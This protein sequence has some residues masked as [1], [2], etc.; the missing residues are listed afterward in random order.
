MKYKALYVLVASALTVANASAQDTYRLAFSQKDDIEI[1]LDGY[2]QSNWCQQR[3]KARVVGGPQASLD[4]FAQLLPKLGGLFAAQCPQA[5]LF[6]WTFFDATGKQIAEGQA[7]ASTQWAYSLFEPEQT[8]PEAVISAKDNKTKNGDTQQQE[9][10]QIAKKDKNIEA[11]SAVKAN[12]PEL[13]IAESAKTE[14]KPK[15]PSE[16]K[17]L[18]QAEDKTDI[19]ELSV[20]EQKQTALFTPLSAFAVGRWAPPTE[21]QRKELISG[22]STRKDQNGCVLYSAF[23]FGTQ[24][25]YIQ[26]VS[27]KLTCTQE[28]YLQGQGTLQLMRSDGAALTRAIDVYA[29]NG[30]PFISD[31]KHLHPDAIVYG[32]GSNYWFSVGSDEKLQSHYL[33][34]ARIQNYDGLGLWRIPDELHVLTGST[35]S[36]KQAN[37]IA[38]QIDSA[39]SY[40][41]RVFNSEHLNRVSIRFADDP[42]NGLA[43]RYLNGVLYE[44]D[45]RR[46]RNSYRSPYGPWTYNMQGASNYLFE[47]EAKAQQELE[48]EQERERRRLEEEER[49]KQMRQQAQARA[50]KQKIERQLRENASNEQSRLRQYQLLLEKNLSE[51][52]NLHEHIYRNVRNDFSGLSEYARVL[53]RGITMPISTLVEVTGEKNGKALVSWPYEMHLESI[54][55][56]KKGW[57]WIR[58][59]QRFDTATLDKTGLPMTIVKIEPDSLYA[60]EKKQCTELQ[61]PLALYRL[62][63]SNPQW[64]PSQAEKQVNEA[65]EQ[66]LIY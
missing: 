21:E 10:V 34:P 39:V 14:E 24:D 26:L 57:Y 31:V 1:F 61:D 65:K 12:A 16:S 6:D 28:G 55:K 63:I 41:P 30:I 19:T 32:G 15:E 51:G 60:C 33:V 17:G 23:N 5:S 53:Q 62:T 27:N 25:E 54:E 8:K 35:E 56:L 52:N 59:D 7:K 64:D 22:L 47:R 20:D 42:E 49:L 46:S 44:I 4:G 45:A 50:E 48:R 29:V 11:A 18:A 13:I 3:L 38:Q 58:G 36:F 43:N 2:T 40:I 9:E 37:D 66:G